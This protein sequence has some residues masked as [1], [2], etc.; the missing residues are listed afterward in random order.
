MAGLEL[1]QLLMCACRQGFMYKTSA[2]FRAHF[3]AKR[4]EMWS[5]NE[6]LRNCRLK[7]VRLE[8][9]NLRL[10]RVV[11]R[12]VMHESRTTTMRSIT[13]G[14][15]KKVAASQRWMCVRCDKLLDATYEIDHIV[16]LFKGGGNDMDNL[17][18]LC[19]ECHGTK[20]CLERRQSTT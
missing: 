2:S 5:M 15:K 8:Q 17:N 13:T 12:L 6:E 10:T 9:E 11:D 20:T 7:I 3:K 19:R 1:K 18:A 16:P 14:Q 4:H